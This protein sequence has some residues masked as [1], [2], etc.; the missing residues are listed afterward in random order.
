[1][2]VSVIAV[3]VSM[4]SLKAVVTVLNVRFIFFYS[5]CA[6]TGTTYGAMSVLFSRAKEQEGW[7]LLTAFIMHVKQYVC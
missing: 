7:N 4:S 5:L 2:I 3:A 6:F 1:M